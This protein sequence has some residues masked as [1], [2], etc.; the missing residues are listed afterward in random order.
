MEWKCEFCHDTPHTIRRSSILCIVCGAGFY[1][2]IAC[3]Q[4]DC[5]R[6]CVT[7]AK[8]RKDK[9]ENDH[10]RENSQSL[11]STKLG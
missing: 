10:A 11:S 8:R 4:P 7:E 6:E 2:F 5:E 9:L 1:E 3:E